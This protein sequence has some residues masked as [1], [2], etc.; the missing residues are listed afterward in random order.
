MA[1]FFRFRRLK[2]NL[3]FPGTTCFFGK[4]RKNAVFF[5]DANCVYKS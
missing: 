3:R 1:W 2:P 4:H 5:A